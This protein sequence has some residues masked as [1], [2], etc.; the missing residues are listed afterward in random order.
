MKDQVAT[1]SGKEAH[2]G[3]PYPIFIKHLLFTGCGVGGREWEG[4]KM[5]HLWILFPRSYRLYTEASNLDLQKA[6]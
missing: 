4:I 5:P 3:F 1:F 2:G 6:R